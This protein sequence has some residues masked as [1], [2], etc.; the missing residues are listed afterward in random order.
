[1][2]SFRP[3][4]KTPSVSCS[5]GVPSPAIKTHFSLF[6][7]FII[8]Q[9]TSRSHNDS[10]Q[11]D[12]QEQQAPDQGE[13]PCPVGPPPLL[14]PLGLPLLGGVVGQQLELLDGGLAGAVDVRE[15]LL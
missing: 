6:F 5:A 4:L 3:G 11:Y 12:P 14:L 9:L 8:L 10:S 13:R 15:A 7:T 1:M 2:F